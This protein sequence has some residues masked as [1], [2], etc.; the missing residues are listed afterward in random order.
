MSNTAYTDD[1]KPQNVSPSPQR[2]QRVAIPSV[3]EVGDVE[4]EEDVQPT[5]LFST[6]GR[7]FALG[8]SVVALLLV[9]AVVIFIVSARNAPPPATGNVASTGKIQSSVPVIANISKTGAVTKGSVP[10]NF[11]WTDPTSG[12]KM[13]LA[14]L[15]G[16]PVWINFWGTWCPPCRGEMPE[17]QKVYNNHKN[18]VAILGISMGPRDSTEAVLGFLGQFRYDWTFIHD[19]DQQLAVKYQ[20]SA[21]PMSYFIG[22]DGT[23][24]AISVGGIQADAMEKLLTQAR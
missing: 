16:K 14:G 1:S 24:K 8:S 18:D 3:V 20:A 9:F 6:P 10:P 17:M 13:S 5:G 23:V 15:K 2:I 4:E 22:S 7:A 11:E 12:Q 21:I 19:G